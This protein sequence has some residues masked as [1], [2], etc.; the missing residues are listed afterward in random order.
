MLAR[1]AI[2]LLAFAA[3]V[4]AAETGLPDKIDYGRHIRPILSN[5]C[6]RCHGPDAESRQAGLRFD[7]REVAVAALDSGKVAIVPG[8]GDASELV[9]RIS[10]SDAD[11]VMP[12]PSSNKTLSERD[13]QLLR[14]W[15]DQG[16]EYHPH[17][18]FVAPSLGRCRRLSVPTGRGTE[19]TTSYWRGWKPKGLLRRQR[20]SAAFCCAG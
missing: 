9:R 10:S 8:H 6:F 3:S 17:W 18:A 1:V 2:V 19:S 12:P 4:D 14:R 13:K 7:V 20:P 5:I 16:A 15:I 11:T